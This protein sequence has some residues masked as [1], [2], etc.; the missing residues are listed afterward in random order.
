MAKIPKQEFDD[1]GNHRLVAEDNRLLSYKEVC[2]MENFELE[3][4]AAQFGEEYEPLTRNWTF[5]HDKLAE[6]VQVIETK[7]LRNKELLEALEDVLEGIG[8]LS[9]GDHELEG[10]GISLERA[11]E[12]RAVYLRAR[13][14]R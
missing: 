7:H 4:L 11:K 8:F 12:I 6:F 1:N 9:G 14:Y 10:Y 13:G 5:K 2:T 3:K